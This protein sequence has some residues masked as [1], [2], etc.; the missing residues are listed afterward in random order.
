MDRFLSHIPSK[1][2]ALLSRTGSFKKWGVRRKRG[3]STA[4]AD[5]NGMYNSNMH[6]FSTNTLLQLPLPNH[7][8]LPIYLHQAEVGGEVGVSR[9][10]MFFER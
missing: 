4:P 2:A 3:D 9:L 6:F 1:G 5:A 8:Q 7:S 10:P